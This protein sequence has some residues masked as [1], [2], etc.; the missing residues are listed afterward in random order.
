[1]QD[2]SLAY[3]TPGTANYQVWFLRRYQL[4]ASNCWWR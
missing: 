2:L 4:A 3:G 1:M